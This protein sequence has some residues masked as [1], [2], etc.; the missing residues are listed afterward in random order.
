[1]PVMTGT[2]S[3]WP[4]VSPSRWPAAPPVGVVFADTGPPVWCDRYLFVRIAVSA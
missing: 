3:I 2:K 1:M 4:V